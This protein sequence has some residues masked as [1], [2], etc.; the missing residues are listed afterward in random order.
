MISFQ[1][2]RDWFYRS[3]PT[4]IKSHVTKEAGISWATVNKIF[5]DKTV[6]TDMIAQLCK[7]YNL[8]VEQVIVFQN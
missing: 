8:K 3:H 4:K 1:P 6:Q 2:F 7:T 5:D